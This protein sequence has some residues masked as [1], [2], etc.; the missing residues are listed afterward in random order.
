MVVLQ[1]LSV[2]GGETSA[3]FSQNVGR[4]VTCQFHPSL[5][6]LYC[7]TADAPG[8]DGTCIV[9]PF[10][11]DQFAV[12]RPTPSYAKILDTLD[13]DAVATPDRCG[14]AGA[15]ACVII[16]PLCGA[17][18]AGVHE[19]L[20]CCLFHPFPLEPSIQSDCTALL[21][22]SLSLSPS[23]LPCSVIHSPTHSLT[24]SFAFSPAQVATRCAAALSRACTL[25]HRSGFS[26]ASL[27]APRSNALQVGA[28]SVG[29]S[30]RSRGREHTCDGGLLV[31][32]TPLRHG[33]VMGC[34]RIIIDDTNTPKN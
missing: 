7:C 10:F 22:A 34:G 21:R 19:S 11:K 1:S 27:A 23:L 33:P 15:P 8:R 3:P 28:F 25:L 6:A 13:A 9:D 24:R 18:G 20:T 31:A 26:G 12:A 4:L 5:F 32:R 30:E 16:P 14:D 2:S 29:A 17:R